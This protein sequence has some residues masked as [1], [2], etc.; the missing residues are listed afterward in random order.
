MFSAESFEI[1]RAINCIKA[2]ADVGGSLQED[3]RSGANIV[4]DTGTVRG[5]MSVHWG[6]S[7]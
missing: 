1:Q 5:D 2:G 4:H 3:H 7:T 6:K